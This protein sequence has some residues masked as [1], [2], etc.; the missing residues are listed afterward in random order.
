MFK[1]YKMDNTVKQEKPKA[2]PKK[3]VY[4]GTVL[5]NIKIGTKYNWKQG[6]K[7]TGLSK[8]ENDNYKLN[9][10]IE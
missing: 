2:K 10:I 9:K 6:Q 1:K 8:E 4:S 5:K 3:K 7:V